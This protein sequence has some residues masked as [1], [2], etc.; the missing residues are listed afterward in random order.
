[1]VHG[2]HPVKLR[3]TNYSTRSFGATTTVYS[4]FN[5]DAGFG[6]PDQN[7][8]GEPEG[9]TWYTTTEVVQ[10]EDKVQYQREFTKKKILFIANQ[11]DGPCN[12]YDALKAPCVY[13]ILGENETSDDQAL[14]HKRGAYFQLEK[15]PGMDW[16]DSAIS[17]M[18]ATKRSLSVVS[19]WFPVFEVPIGGLMP[20]VFPLSWSSDIPGHNH[21]AHGMKDLNGQPVIIGKSWQ[22]TWFGNQGEH[23]WSRT[24]FNRLMD[25]PGNTAFTLA[26]WDG[27]IQTIR[28][29]IIYR[30]QVLISLYIIKLRGL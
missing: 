25:I 15:E 12:I 14:T 26:Q 9:C 16:F 10:D 4:P 6:F 7:A 28:Y 29:A 8:E 30:L 21:K 3:K 5:L 11:T 22:G 23:Y 20:E 19:P 17:V 18:Q 27:T 24:A 1:M 13:G 2:V